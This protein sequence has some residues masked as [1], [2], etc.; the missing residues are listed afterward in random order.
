[1]KINS[2]LIENLYGKDF[3]LTFFEDVTILTGLNGSG[4]TSIL[5]ILALICQGKIQ[6]VIKFDFNKLE[7]HY[8]VKNKE[9]TLVIKK[10]VENGDRYEAIV[11]S[12]IEHF[13]IKKDRFESK[14]IESKYVESSSFYNGSSSFTN[15]KKDLDG[16]QSLKQMINEDL[17]CIYIPL[18]RKI[19]LNK[20]REI[21][22]ERRSN[23]FQNN[24]DESTYEC[25]QYLCEYIRWIKFKENRTYNLTQKLILKKFFS[26]TASIDTKNI[27]RENFKINEKEKELLLKYDLKDSFDT[28]LREY[29]DTISYL[30]NN[31]NS[32]NELIKI[33][34]YVRHLIAYEQLKKFNIILEFI[35]QRHRKINE[36]NNEISTLEEN[37]NFFFKDTKKKILLS[38]LN[39]LS[40]GK[41]EFKN[42][43]TLHESNVLKLS[44]GEKQLFIMLVASLI[45]DT[46]RL[47]KNRIL[48]IDEPELSLHIEWQSNL[49]ETMINNI[50]KQQLIIATHSPEIVGYYDEK[51]IEV[52]GVYRNE[53]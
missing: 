14:Y 43:E 39:N 46:N 8:T 44:S 26:T 27:K 10:D 53:Y 25:E 18:S 36:L 24:I 29:T 20:P 34:H 35:D 52:K 41:V 7:L 5:N 23:N 32:L 28:V 13:Y 11:D 31:N 49:L 19:N 12:N 48:I 47:D 16:K 51:C 33:E 4:K 17:S 40:G 38:D 9:K 22:I 15:N 30:N 45:T 42:L 21:R 50:G 2:L 6:N 37:I 3:H 1:M